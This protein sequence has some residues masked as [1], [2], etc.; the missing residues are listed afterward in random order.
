MPLKRFSVYQE[1][2][3]RREYVRVG[4]DERETADSRTP[5][6]YIVKLPR[7]IED[8]VSVELVGYDFSS[9]LAPTFLGNLQSR[10]PLREDE[11]MH[12]F[13][14]RVF[15]S[16]GVDFV[17]LVVDMQQ[18]TAPDYDYSDV[19][20]TYIGGS[21]RAVDTAITQ[22]LA[23]QGN[24]AVNSTNTTVTVTALDTGQITI[25][26]T[27]TGPVAVDSIISFPAAGS[28]G[29][30]LGFLDD[31]V[32]YS[33][34]NQVITSPQAVNE[35][36]TRF[37]DVHLREVPELQPL[38]RVYLDRPYAITAQYDNARMPRLPRVLTDSL[39]R[40]ETLTVRL[41]TGD[42]ER[43][44]PLT[45]P[46]FNS[47]VFEVLSVRPTGACEIPAWLKQAFVL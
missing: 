16:N 2:Y 45:A 15:H 43:E 32:S 3:L 10:R 31:T 44:I 5:F 33:S 14:L 12:I 6:D 9:A 41:T 13:N 38:A 17:D 39:R 29:P 46:I 30:A 11:G 25:A 47:L 40:L 23:T 24:A 42:E 19:L 4:A 28:A 35:Q 22:A 8:V 7:P 27:R 21:S 37:V 1:P 34:V 26:F 36:P 20:V 18:P